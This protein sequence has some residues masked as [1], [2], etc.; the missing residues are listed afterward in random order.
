MSLLDPRSV[1]IVGAS[2]DHEKVGHAVLQNLIEQGFTG[3]IYPINPKHGEILGK[4]SYASISDLPKTPDLVII[5]TPAPTV[6]G[7]LRECGENHV[8]QVVIISAGFGETGTADGY[9][10]E[11]EIVSIAEEFDIQVIGPNCL[12]I[13]RPSISMNASFAK[14][15]PQKGNVA[16]IS[17]SGAFAVALLDASGPL[18]LGYSAVLSIGNKTVLDECD[19]LKI[20][21]VDKQT[22]VIGLYLEN[23]KDSQ[24]FREVASR[25]A[26]TKPI[27]LIKAGRTAAGRRAAASHTGALAGSDAAIDAIC[28]GIGVHRAD[29]LQEFID[30]LQALAAP[31]LLSNRV[32]IITNAG[33]PGILAADAAATEGLE[34]PPL[35]QT[36]LAT[37]KIKL[38]GTASTGNPIDVVGDAK[39]D[40]YVA[41]LDACGDDPGIDGVAVL[42]T[43][44]VMTPVKEVATA[45]ID[46]QKR[47][48]LMP[49]VG[50]FMG[51]RSV[52]EGIDML[53]EAN[54]P[55]FPT[56]ERAIHALAQLRKQTPLKNQKKKRQS[57]ARIEKAALHL[58]SQEKGLLPEEK[59]QA[60]LE[61]YGIPTASQALALSTDDA[62]RLAEEIGYPVVL[63]VSSPDVIHKTEAGGVKIDLKNVKD[64]RTAFD[65]IQQSISER[66]PHSTIRGILVQKFLPV[67]SEFI[68][69][70][71][72]DPYAGPLIM[73]GLGGI[74]AELFADTAFRLAPV[75]EEEAYTMLAQLRSWKLLTGLR[76]KAPLD[77]S[78]L[79]RAVAHVSEMMAECLEIMELDLNPVMVTESGIRLADARIII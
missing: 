69:G 53:R 78:A 79:A 4:K 54:I 35:G 14:D 38:P 52:E 71:L 56:P 5:I 65:A 7:V 21:A 8:K 62:I 70:G 29:S 36:Q 12:G 3:G 27:V 48:P 40:R 44:Q 50:C 72:R 22:K 39:V 59:T 24:C 41:A 60:L 2:S 34:L 63:K 58:S 25:I 16:L 61:L 66:M 20:L 17:Q 42:L 9:M 55:N 77:I 26:E 76:G 18:G 51:G 6:A 46:A 32:A 1:G 30:L 23:I 28:S 10:Y 19:M 37:L 13:L 68:I 47:A 57:S 75:S 64:V 33:G 73:V 67:G 74:Y 45:V 43:P 15:L 49:I 31:P 11:E